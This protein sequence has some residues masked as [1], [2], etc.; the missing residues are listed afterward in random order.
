MRKANFIVGFSN[1]GKSYLINHLYGKTIFH[2]SNLHH[3]DN[4]NIKQGFIVHPQSNDDLGRDYIIQIDKRLKV[5]KPQRAD[6]FS[7]ICPATEKRYNWL[8]IIQDKRIDSFKEFNLFLL[9]Y[10]WDHHAELKIEE[11][12]AS[13]GENEN[14][15]YYII[16]QGERCELTA[17]LEVKLQQII[18]HPEDIY[19]P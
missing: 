10:K 3:L 8:E 11:V 9:K 19:N 13:L 18:R 4:S 16:D 2:N 6:L 14:I 12:K 5:Y 17:R 1:W 15:N 7:T